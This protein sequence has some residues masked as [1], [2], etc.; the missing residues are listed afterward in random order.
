MIRISHKH[1]VYGIFFNYIGKFFE[2]SYII[3]TLRGVH[4]SRKRKMAASG[5]A[6][7]RVWQA[8]LFAYSY[9][10]HEL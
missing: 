7:A 10:I 9:F 3:K 1:D 6:T 4:T 5:R 8:K 2:F